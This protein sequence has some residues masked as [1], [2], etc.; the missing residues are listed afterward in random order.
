MVQKKKTKKTKELDRRSQRK[1]N[2]HKNNKA[3]LAQKLNLC[4]LG[5]FFL[6][7]SPKLAHCQMLKAP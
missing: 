2:G 7:Q 5:T 4:V 1:K 3:F 6:L